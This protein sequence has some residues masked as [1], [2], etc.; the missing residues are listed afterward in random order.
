MRHQSRLSESI[1]EAQRAPASHVHK[2]RVVV[3]ILRSGFRFYD[4]K[5]K[6]YGKADDEIREHSRALAKFREK[7]VQ[8]ELLQW[9]KR[10]GL[11]LDL[12]K[13]TPPIPSRGAEAHVVRLCKI[14]QKLLARLADEERVG[15]VRL[16]ELKK[17]V[18]GYRG[19]DPDQIHRIRKR[20]KEVEYQMR[21]Y[22]PKGKFSKSERRKV[23][24]VGKNLG[25][26]RDI[27]LL[28]SKDVSVPLSET[29]RQELRRMRK[30]LER[31]VFERLRKIV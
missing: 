8:V 21:F 23:A 9:L 1:H 14:A 31:R 11:R 6:V 16:S 20:I 27:W 10:K 30:K 26:I 15:R 17:A 25:R 13:L 28:E 19:F 3:K 7:E 18:K 2:I 24:K 5:L 12:P 22:V 4:P 29:Q